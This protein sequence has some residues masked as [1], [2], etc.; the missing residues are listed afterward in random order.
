MP[1]GQYSGMPRRW[2]WTIEPR[3]DG[4]W[5]VQRHGSQRADGLHDRKGTA[6]ARGAELGQ[7]YHGQLRVKGENGRIQDER[8]YGWDPFPPR[9]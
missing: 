4:Q 6:V 8:T 3:L 5:A 9:G 1:S 7:R 2:T